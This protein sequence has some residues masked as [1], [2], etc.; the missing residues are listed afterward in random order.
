MKLCGREKCIYSSVQGMIDN[1]KKQVAERQEIAY[2]DQ[3]VVAKIYHIAA[4]VLSEACRRRF[5]VDKNDCEPSKRF[6]IEQLTLDVFILLNQLK[7]DGYIDEEYKQTIFDELLKIN[8]EIE[9]VIETDR[10]KGLI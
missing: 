1:M 4:A 10:A 6:K 7:E 5:E 3:L 9:K 2:P 8:P